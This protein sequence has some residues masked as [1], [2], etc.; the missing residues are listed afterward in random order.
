M[1]LIHSIAHH[2]ITIPKFTFPTEESEKPAFYCDC[3][4]V[5]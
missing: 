5:Q 3:E 4:F 2:V 1:I